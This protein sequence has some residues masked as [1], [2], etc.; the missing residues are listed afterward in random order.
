MRY[1]FTLASVAASYYCSHSCPGKSTSL[2]PSS[3]SYRGRLSEV[4]FCALLQTATDDSTD[5]QIHVNVQ[6]S[7]HFGNTAA[8]SLRCN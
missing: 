7:C 5:K 2:T 6:P 8:L 1:S 3:H 4:T